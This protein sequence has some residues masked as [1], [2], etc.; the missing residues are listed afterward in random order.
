[1]LLRPGPRALWGVRPHA[2]L[3]PSLFLDLGVRPRMGS[4]PFLN[5]AINDNQEDHDARL[6]DGNH[7]TVDSGLELGRRTD[8]RGGRVLS[9][10][11][12]TALRTRA[13]E[14]PCGQAQ[15][16][17]S[18]PAAPRRRKHQRI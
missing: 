6:V 10:S 16:L 11:M 13:A 9:S 3:T 17:G 12:D 14:P 1:Y 7:D 18:H 2:G 4:D 8:G 5:P 15:C